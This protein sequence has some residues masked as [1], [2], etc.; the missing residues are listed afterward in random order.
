[1]HPKGTGTK[2]LASGLCCTATRESPVGPEISLCDCDID[3]ARTCRF[4]GLSNLGPATH[5]GGHGS[6]RKVRSAKGAR[7][8]YLCLTHHVVCAAG[9]QAEQPGALDTRR[10][11]EEQTSELQSL[12]R[13]SKAVFC[14]K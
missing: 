7:F 12:M 8:P 3:H 5:A 9:H 14:L 11:S 13:I 10:R 2:L 4:L 1:M 6:V